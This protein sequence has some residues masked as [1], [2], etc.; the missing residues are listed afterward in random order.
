MA[1]AVRRLIYLET[2]YDRRILAATAISL[3]YVTAWAVLR[4]S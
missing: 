2:K 1:N 4:F 3:A